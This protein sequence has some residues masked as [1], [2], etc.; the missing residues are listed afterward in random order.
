MTG[1]SLPLSW[2]ERQCSGAVAEGLA[3]VSLWASALIDPRFGDDRDRVSP[4]QH[5]LLYMNLAAGLGDEGH[6][7]G[8][9]R[10][11]T[12]SAAL[13]IRAMLGCATLD[14]ALRAAARLYGLFSPTLRLRLSTD[15]D[16][17]M[18]AIS[19]D[20]GDAA[21][22]RY[23]EDCYA[24]F[25]FM[26][27]THFLGRPLPLLDMTTSDP[28]HVNLGRLHWAALAPVRLSGVTM[29][30]FPKSLLA[31]RRAGAS[32]ELALWDVFEPWLDFVE[33]GGAAATGFGARSLAETAS[34][35]GVSVST[36]R[37]RLQARQGGFR[38]E[39]RRRLSAI[40]VERLTDSEV[41]VEAIAAELGYSDARA[42][43]RFIKGTTG[44]TPQ[45]IRAERG[46]P[47][48]PGAV[49]ARI[50]SL[51]TALNF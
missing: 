50:R 11:P 41:S 7:L 22:R 21:R 26:C 19:C 16:I 20:K 33:R 23:L 27:C 12:G 14:A 49:R 34:A 31:A 47:G 37:R 24:G 38:L 25:L 3:Q 35:R 17:A 1:S 30:R 13:A 44:R 10:I 32:G 6:G 5:A 43:R 51:A 9:S 18:L 8:G 29:L 39:N 40:G 4:A 28:E 46:L 48:M 15:H 42:F 36:L 45:Q 2:V